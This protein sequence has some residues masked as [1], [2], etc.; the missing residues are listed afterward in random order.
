MWA[1]VRPGRGSAH[2]RPRG[3]FCAVQRP[4]S[5]G[6]AVARLC[7]MPQYLPRPTL[8]T[9]RVL[10]EGL[11]FDSPFAQPRFADAVAALPLAALHDAIADVRWQGPRVTTWGRLPDEDADSA[12]WS[13]VAVITLAS[14][15][16]YQVRF[17]WAPDALDGVV[18]A[19]RTSG[20]A[21]R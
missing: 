17:T 2:R 14:G 3:Y 1:N 19:R 20:R 6:R 21:F 8:T 7:G 13:R 16:R 15:C 10:P 11:R 9:W 5:E 18:T 12:T 4:L